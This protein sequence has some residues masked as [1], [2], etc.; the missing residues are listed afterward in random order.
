MLNEGKNGFWRSL[1]QRSTVLD[2]LT[3]GYILGFAIALVLLG[4]EDKD[5]MV[6]FLVHVGLL[7]VTTAIIHFWHDQ[8]T[9]VRGFIRQLY[10]GLLYTFFYREMQAASFWVFPRF[11]DAELVAFERAVF[12]AD[13]NVWIVPAQSAWL[14]EIMMAGYFSYYLLIP[15]VAL[16]LFFKRRLAEVRGLLTATTLAF[17][18]S[19]VGFVLFP[20]E[21][22]RHFL[23]SQFP[24]PLSGGFFVPLVT[25]IIGRVAIHGG[26][27]PS[28]HVAVALVVLV[29]AW[30]TMPNLGRILTPFVAVLCVATVWG[31]FHYVTDIMVGVIVGV[32]ALVLSPT[33]DPEPA[34]VMNNLPHR[35]P[36]VQTAGTR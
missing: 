16:P 28:S 7:A 12:G 5:W 8:T 19:Y 22:P 2:R 6:L 13:P 33:Y 24:A 9:G 25:W 34:H 4:R 26:C 15:V 10:P 30:K 31:R 1:W 11:L 29:W 35:E 23:A 21:G 27:M 3:V 18:I 20:V 32:V 36:Q 17:V 14:N